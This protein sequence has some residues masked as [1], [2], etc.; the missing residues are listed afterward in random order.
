MKPVTN[1]SIIALLHGPDQPGLVSRVSSWIFLR[2]SNIIHA[3]QHQDHEANI[4]FQ[5]VEFDDLTKAVNIDF[6]SH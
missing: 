6:K 4:F 1:P 3:D 2:G 5:R